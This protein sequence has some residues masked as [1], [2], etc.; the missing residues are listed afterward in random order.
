MS[1]KAKGTRREHASRR[2]LEAEGYAVVR[3]AGSK[4]A[5]DLIG[6]S[7]RDVVLVQ[8][9]SRDWPGAME[10]DALVGFPCPPGCRR[11]VHRW[12]DR[13]PIPDVREL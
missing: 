2:L 11:L 3:A 9:K 6:V 1:S 4:G 8:V 13:A 10:M 12:R 7:S 5:W